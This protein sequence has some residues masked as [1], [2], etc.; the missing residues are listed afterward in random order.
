MAIRETLADL[1]I[2]AASGWDIFIIFI[3]L[4]AVLTYGFFLGRNRMIILLLSSYFSLSI[5][6]AIP[7]N[8]L[9]SFSWLGVNQEPSSSAKTFIFLALIV[10]FYLLIPR[11]VLSSTLRIR[12]RGEAAWW[13]LFVLS[14]AQVGLLAMVIFSFL[15]SEIIGKFNFIVEKTFIGPEAQFV[16]VLLPILAMVLMRRKKKTDD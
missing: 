16:W 7:W 2:G 14:I 4:A 15:P 6:K 5:I 10:L 13:Q 1:S 3:F 8:S 12:K 11:S 9:N